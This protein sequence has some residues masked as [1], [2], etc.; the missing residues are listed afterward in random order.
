M[1][2]LAEKVRLRLLPGSSS[3]SSY[4]DD[5]EMDSKEEM[6][7]ECWYHISSNKRV[8]RCHV[9]ST[10]VLS[11]QVCFVDSLCISHG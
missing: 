2:M 7:D 11:G 6:K 8:C 10:T 1:V 5:E 3:Q 4:G 9:S